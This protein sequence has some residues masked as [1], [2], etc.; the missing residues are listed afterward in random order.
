MD[1]DELVCV[2]GQAAPSVRSEAAEVAE[3]AQP[4]ARGTATC[5]HWAR[6]WCMR[7]DVPLCPPSAPGAVGVHQDLLLVLE[8][9][10]RV[11]AIRLNC[12]AHQEGRLHDVVEAVPSGGLPAVGYTVAHAG[13]G[14]GIAMWDGSLAHP[15][16]GG[17]PEG[18]GVPP[19]S[20]SRVGVRV[21]HPSRGHGP[22]AVAGPS[23]NLLP[24]LGAAHNG[25]ILGAMV[26]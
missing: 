11:G 8:T 13:V 21:A 2:G 4:N 26:G 23:G 14:S 20:D 6:G 9:I 24:V 12:C 16:P 10:A 15:T 19:G 3:R 1:D 5:R 25:R 18:P 17:S 7:A 22:A